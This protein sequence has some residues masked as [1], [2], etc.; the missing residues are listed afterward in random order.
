MDNLLIL[1][2]TIYFFSF[3][4]VLVGRLL[5]QFYYGWIY[6]HVGFFPN[7]FTTPDQYRENEAPISF[8]LA[9]TDANFIRNAGFSISFFL[10]FIGSLAVVTGIVYL[11]YKFMHKKELWYP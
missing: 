9:T 1:V 10:C 3:V 4:K 7:F 11:L 8:K 2:Q 6:S 5:A